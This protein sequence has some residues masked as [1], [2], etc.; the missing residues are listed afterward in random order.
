MGEE[1]KEKGEGFKLKERRSCEGE[2]YFEIMYFEIMYFK[3]MYFKIMPDE[4][5]IDKNIL[6]DLEE[7]REGGL[8][9]AI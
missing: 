6:E 5:L 2:I 9:R 3:I 7:R 4:G 8:H 1:G